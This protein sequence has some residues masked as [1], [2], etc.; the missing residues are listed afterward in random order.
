MPRDADALQPVPTPTPLDAGR[1]D[2]ASSCCIVYSQHEAVRCLL[3]Q[4]PLL[5]DGKVLASL[6]KACQ[7]CQS[8]AAR[9][10]VYALC[11]PIAARL[12]LAPAKRDRLPSPCP[13][14]VPRCPPCWRTTKP[15]PADN[16]ERLPRPAAPWRGDSIPA[17]S[18]W[19]APACHKRRWCCL[20]PALVLAST[21]R[22]RRRWH[23]NTHC[24]CALG[25]G[26]CSSLAREPSAAKENRDCSTCRLRV[27][28]LRRCK[29][30]ARLGALAGR[31]APR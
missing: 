27:A 11:A 24:D 2:A 20:P 16:R 4:D 26:A 13:V 18:A 10:S 14:R 29:R 3:E 28:S 1:G 31:I 30:R 19:P 22:P 8:Y 15:R 9:Q 7:R 5:P 12:L 23:V 6:Q 17:G 21:P 25:Y